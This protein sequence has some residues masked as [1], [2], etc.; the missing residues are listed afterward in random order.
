MRRNFLLSVFM[1]ASKKYFPSAEDLQQFQQFAI[2]SH[3]VLVS[4]E[5]HA[6]LFVNGAVPFADDSYGEIYVYILNNK[7]ILFYVRL[8][9]NISFTSAHF[10]NISGHFFFVGNF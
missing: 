3:G 8:W 4:G 7:A 6:I 2:F 1:V 9:V 5:Y 10:L